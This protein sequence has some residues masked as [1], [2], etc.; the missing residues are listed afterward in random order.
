PGDIVF[1]GDSSGGGLA[2]AA[3]V[4]LRELGAPMPRALVLSSPWVDLTLSGESHGTNA[5]HPNPS[6]AS[7]KRAAEW[8]APAEQHRDALV[9]PLYAD[10]TGLPAT[11]VQAGG[12]EV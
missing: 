6:A 8:Y 1:S 4:K 12:H 2:V 9:S 11:L 10:L 7:L 5:A 3:L